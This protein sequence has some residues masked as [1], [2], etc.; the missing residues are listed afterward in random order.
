MEYPIGDKTRPVALQIQPADPR[1]KKVKDFLINAY[2]F[3]LEQLKAREIHLREEQKKL[4]KE[5]DDLMAQ[6]NELAKNLVR[7]TKADLDGMHFLI[8]GKEK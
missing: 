4:D 6:R 7:A 2:D 1:A 8:F 5:Y 3:K